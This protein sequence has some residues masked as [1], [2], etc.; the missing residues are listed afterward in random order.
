MSTFGT[1]LEDVRGY[2][3]L[4]KT[5]YAEKLDVARQTVYDWAELEE[6][7]PKAVDAVLTA[8]PEV[9]R[10]WLETG[11]G[12][13]L[14]NNGQARDP[15]TPYLAVPP[16]EDFVEVP[17]FGEVSA[18]PGQAPQLEP[19]R[20]ERMAATEFAHTFRQAPPRSGRTLRL[21]LFV[22][23]GSSAAPTYFA[24]EYV[25]VELLPKG[26]QRFDAD[27]VYVFRWNGD[28]MLKRLRRLEDKRIEAASLN[29]SLRPFLFTPT[30]D[31]FEV[32]GR[33]IEPE[34]QQLYAVLVARAL[35]LQKSV[36]KVIRSE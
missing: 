13:M 27:C 12:S 7:N 30:E 28:L 23:R 5:V 3:R 34:K 22:V 17:V 4:T 9:S 1:R 25:P 10:R 15:K 20:Y 19:M 35:D 6:Y 11:E 21:G 31:N 2:Y 29:P 8:F 32:I 14:E 36:N 24:G 16:D 26:N 18:G 33:V